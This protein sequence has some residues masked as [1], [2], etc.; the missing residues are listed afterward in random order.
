MAHYEECSRNYELSACDG[1]LFVRTSR[2][3]LT[4]STICEGHADELE[5]SLDAI[6]ERY[7]E[8]NHHPDCSCHGCTG[9]PY[10]DPFE[11]GW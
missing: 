1:E 3:G 5:L 10:N 2:T 7:P 4:T 9:N 6:A 8:M 11:A